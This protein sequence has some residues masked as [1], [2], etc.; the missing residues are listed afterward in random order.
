MRATV[1]PT[2]L[3][4]SF[5]GFGQVR[6]RRVSGKRRRDRTKS[7][8]CCSLFGGLGFVGQLLAVCFDEIFVHQCRDKGGGNCRHPRRAQTAA[9]TRPLSEFAMRYCKA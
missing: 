2:T 9:C 1:D 4:R 7:G 6:R 5:V 3:E 8:L